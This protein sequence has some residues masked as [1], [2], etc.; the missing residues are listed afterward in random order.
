MIL[1]H[2]HPS[3]HLRPSHG[4]RETTRRL[5]EVSEV[6]GIEILDHLIVGDGYLSMKAQGLL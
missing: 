1:A 4:D 3:G 5:V 6:V 2:N